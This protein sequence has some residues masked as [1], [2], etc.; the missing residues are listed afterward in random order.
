M[1][2]LTERME[3]DNE[4]NELFGINKEYIIPHLWLLQVILWALISSKPH[5]V[6]NS[7]T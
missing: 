7:V 2:H 4:L 6:E 1:T 5:L 3:N